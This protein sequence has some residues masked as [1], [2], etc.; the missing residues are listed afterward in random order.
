MIAKVKQLNDDPAGENRILVTLPMMQDDKNG[1]WAR[2]AS[3]YATNKKGSFFIPEVNDD[4]VLGFLN[5]DPN[6]PIILGSLYSSENPPPYELSDE[7][8]TKALVTKEGCK[9]EFDD[10][11]KVVNIET[12]GK[13]KISISDEDKGVTIVDE[14]K[15]S[16]TTDGEGITMEDSNGSRIIMSDSGIEIHSSSDLKLT[17]TSD[18]S[19]SGIN[20]TNYAKAS[21]KSTGLASAELSASGNTII[22]GAVVMIN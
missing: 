9:I 11:K 1:I 22:K 12:P 15:N 2:L 19:V 6:Y 14:N 3:F 18:I 13:N 7:N 10:E 20:I 16:I 17:A 5:S 4:V 21:M 8:S